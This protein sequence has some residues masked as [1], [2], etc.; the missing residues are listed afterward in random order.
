ME[1]ADAFCNR[2]AIMNLGKVVAIGTPTE[3]KASIGKK[4][5]SMDDVF[6][7]YTGGTIESAG[8]YREAKRTRRTAR[9][10]G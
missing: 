10:L 8:G 2:V 3:L 1:E 7:Y 6:I 4:D 5:P 9:R